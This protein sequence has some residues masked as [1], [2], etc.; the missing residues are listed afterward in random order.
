MIN[1]ANLRLLENIL[2]CKRDVDVFQTRKMELL[3]LF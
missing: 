2:H 1:D 3:L